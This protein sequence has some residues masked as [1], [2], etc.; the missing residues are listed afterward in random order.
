MK[1]STHTFLMRYKTWIDI[2]L[3]ALSPIFFYPFSHYWE[4]YSLNSFVLNILCKFL[5]DFP[6]SLAVMR[7]IFFPPVV[8]CSVNVQAFYA[9]VYLVQSTHEPMLV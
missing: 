1:H 6:R 7:L 5:H 2:H 4:I 9:I 8:L 3:S